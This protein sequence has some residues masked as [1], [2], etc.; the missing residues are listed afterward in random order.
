MIDFIRSSRSSYTNAFWI[1]GFSFSF[2]GFFS[3]LTSFSVSRTLSFSSN[4]LLA[5]IYCCSLSSIA[6][7]ARACPV[8]IMSSMIICCTLSS[9]F[10]R[11][12]EFV[13]AVL[14]FETRSATSS[15][16][17]RNSFSK[18]LYACASSI[19]FRFSRWIFSIRE[20][21]TISWS[22][23]SLMITGISLIPA[24]FAARQRRSPAMI[25]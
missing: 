25:S 9:S 7:R 10:R 13:T 19:G 24:C 17:R 23:Y 18:R 3:S 12:I 11:R 14:L 21:S 8:E 4:T 5:R 20:I 1:T 16:F 2:F 6:R 15:C 22:V